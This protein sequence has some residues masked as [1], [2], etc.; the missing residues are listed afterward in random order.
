MAVLNIVI[1]FSLISWAGK[2][3]D[4]G[5]LALLMGTGPFL[6]LIGRSHH[7]PMTIA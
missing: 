1:P 2:T 4:A 5:V 6:A 3:L 7:G